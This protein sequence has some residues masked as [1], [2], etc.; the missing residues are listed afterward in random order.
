MGN[1]LGLDLLFEALHEGTL[2]SPDLT[3]G[4]IGDFFAHFAVLR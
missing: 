3:I 4:E 2:Y 1:N